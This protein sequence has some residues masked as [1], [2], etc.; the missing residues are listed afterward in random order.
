[1]VK[2][3]KV[4]DK[5][6]YRCKDCKHQFLD[7]GNF[8]GMRTKTEV[9]AFALNLYYDGL[10]TWKIQRHIAKTFKVDVSVTPIWK[11]L[12]KYSKLVNNY[13][14]TLDIKLSGKFHHDETEIKVGGEGRFFWET[15]DED[16]RYI[17]SSLLTQSR[18][19][20]E[21]AK[22][23]KQALEKQRP[24]AFFTDGSF[25]YDDAFNKVF[26]T[27]FK[28]NKVEWIRRVGIRARETNQIIER[29]HGTLK[30]RLRPTRGLKKNKT[31]EKWLNG[32]I[33]NYNFVKPHIALK[34]LTPAQAAGL[35]IKSDWSELIQQA[36]SSTAKKEIKPIE[37]V[38]K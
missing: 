12:M 23:F 4:K 24:I 31:A 6:L 37:V 36:I 8:A 5:Q 21:A 2:N 17:V 16:T 29:K 1:V 30:D 28:S 15:I 34:G 25:A 9:I 18:T 33:V 14:N 27:R 20:E 19:S 11:W 35:N 10:S 26:F 13:V 38:S 7:N 32:Y 22:I 3:G